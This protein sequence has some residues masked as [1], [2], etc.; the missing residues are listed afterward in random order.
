M[1][2]EYTYSYKSTYRHKGVK[3]LNVSTYIKE[4]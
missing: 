1:L 3:K 4:K 2:K